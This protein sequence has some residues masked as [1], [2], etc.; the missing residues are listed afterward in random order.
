[1]EKI[2][3]P[4][5]LKEF[6]RLLTESGVRFMLVGGY[7]LARH[8]YVR[9]TGDID[10]WIDDCAENVARLGGAVVDFGF[11]LNIPDNPFG[12]RNMLRM[13]M[14]PLR[15]EVLKEIS[16]VTFEECWPNQVM[17]V[18]NGFSVPCISK[19]DLIKNKSASARGKDLIDVQ[20]LEGL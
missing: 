13:G 18:V 12:E 8:G 14:P 11:K 19:P 15:I 1:M 17:A 9:A 3:V 4:D 6:L 2:D 16:G 5:E 20:E 7:A 10:L